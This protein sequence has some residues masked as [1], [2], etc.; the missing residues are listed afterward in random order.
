MVSFRR[1]SIVVGLLCVSIRLFL[2]LRV[3]SSNTK[4]DLVKVESKFSSS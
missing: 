3:F 1:V 2:T 4:D